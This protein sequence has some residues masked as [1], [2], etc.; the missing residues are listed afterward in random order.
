MKNAGLVPENA[1]DADK[2]T[3]ITDVPETTVPASDRMP[4]YNVA[5]MARSAMGGSVG[6]DSLGASATPSASI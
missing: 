5:R 3:R 1:T 6:K 2:L 4:G